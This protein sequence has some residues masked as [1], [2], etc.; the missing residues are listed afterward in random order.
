MTIAASASSSSVFWL[1]GAL[2]F[3]FSVQGMNLVM[4]GIGR[5]IDHPS[6]DVSK[7]ISLL[8]YSIT[9]ALLRIVNKPGGSIIYRINAKKGGLLAVSLDWKQKECKNKTPFS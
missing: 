2:R 9:I 6:V 7:S 4:E 1:F 3:S 8:P 5:R